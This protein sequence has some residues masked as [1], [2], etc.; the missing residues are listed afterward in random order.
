LG[1]AYLAGLA[2]G[3]WKNEQD[4][5]AQWQADRRFVRAV[6]PSVP[7]QLLAG[8]SRALARSKHWAKEA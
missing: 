1:A 8:W 5:A 7:K 6:K 3:F 4:I 2:V